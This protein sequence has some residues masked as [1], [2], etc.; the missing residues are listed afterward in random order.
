LAGCSNRV[1]HLLRFAEVS[2]SGARRV[3]LCVFEADTHFH[4]EGQ[5]ESLP[6]CTVKLDIL[7]GTQTVG[8]LPD[9]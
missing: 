5:F 3:V 6:K 4:T 7:S 2:A 1:R 9:M 8:Q